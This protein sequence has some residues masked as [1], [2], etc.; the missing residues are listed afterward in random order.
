METAFCLRCNKR[1]VMEPIRIEKDR[2]LTEWACKECGKR[3]AFL[4]RPISVKSAKGKED[5]DEEEEEG[6]EDYADE[7]EGEDFYG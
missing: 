6:M 4:V 1:T 5:E 3:Y 7:G 2:K